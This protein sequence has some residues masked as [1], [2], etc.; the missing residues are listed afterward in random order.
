MLLRCASE[1]SAEAW[2]AGHQ[3]AAVVQSMQPGPAVLRLNTAALLSVCWQQLDDEDSKP[4]G[5]PDDPFAHVAAAAGGGGRAAPG[6][7]DQELEQRVR[8]TF[9]QEMRRAFLESSWQVGGG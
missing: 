7:S 9:A 3:W 4:A 1:Q 6:G 5:E 8:G 2:P